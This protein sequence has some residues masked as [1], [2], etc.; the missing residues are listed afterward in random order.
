MYSLGSIVVVRGDF[1]FLSFLLLVI[2]KY[3]KVTV[4]VLLCCSLQTV[5]LAR[6]NP[7][8]TL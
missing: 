1:R 5:L 8:A 6:R 3:V 7:S 2:Y 4:V